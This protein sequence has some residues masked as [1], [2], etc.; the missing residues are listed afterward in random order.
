VEGIFVQALG[1]VV[2]LG[3]SA[4]AYRLRA[5]DAWGSVCGF[6]LGLV[7]GL[8]SGW[9]WVAL[10]IA[11]LILGS[12]ATRY[13][14]QFKLS[15]HA[16]EDKKGARGFR[17]VLANGAVPVA[18]SL[19]NCFHQI[20]SLP[21]LYV[22]AISS[23]AAD[24]LATE[25][26]L[27]SHADPVL[28][29]RPSSA[30]PPG[31]SGGVTLLGEGAAVLGASVMACLAVSLGVISFSPLYASAAALAGFV[32]CNIDS[33]LGSTL[34]S[35]NSCIVCSSP[36]EKRVHCGKP[37]RR[38]KGLGPVGNNEVNLLSD[39]VAISLAELLAVLT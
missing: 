20:P 24:T 36:T 30:V 2:L 29:N 5:T 4:A 37:T 9:A 39:L 34:Q 1:T 17:N 26:G 13:R 14:Y 23:A 28:I 10:L 27:L 38:I 3:I 6:G 35:L 11:F 25:I 22:A 21:V 19:I 18:V 8:T 31:I 15:I 32:G 7:I 12:A 16:A 33:L